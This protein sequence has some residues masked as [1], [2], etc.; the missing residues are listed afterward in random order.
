MGASRRVVAGA[1]ARCLLGK[2]GAAVAQR[3]P[4]VRE[5]PSGRGGVVRGMGPCAQSCARGCRPGQAQGP[6]RVPCLRV[7]RL[8]LVGCTCSKFVIS[9]APFM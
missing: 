8:A 9:G 3:R 5:R 6:T 2:L 7:E 4:G 1:V